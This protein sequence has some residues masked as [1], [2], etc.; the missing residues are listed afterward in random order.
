MNRVAVIS[1]A[2]GLMAGLVAGG[3]GVQL[4][5]DNS[6]DL[7]A[8]QKRAT[9][10]VAVERRTL[11]VTESTTGELASSAEQSLTT[12]GSGTITMAATVGATV[13]R[14]GQLARVDDVPSILLTGDQPVW[15]SFDSSMTDGAD[16]RQ[17]ESNLVA[18]GFDP[19][20][21][22]VDANFDSDTAAAIKAWETSLGIP[23]PDGVVDAGQI[24]FVAT[25]VQVT[26]STTAGTRLNAGDST[27]TVRPVDGAGLK[28]TFTV[29]EEADRYQV[30]KPVAIVLT[31]ESRHAATIS[32]FERVAIAGGQQGGLGGGGAQTASF[33]VT[34]TPDHGGAGLSAGPV[35]VEIPT[36]RASDALAVPS[37]ALVAVTE[38]GQ[39][40]RLAD[41]DRLVAV[42]IGV[43]ADGWV[44]VTGDDIFEGTKIV[45]PK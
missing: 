43:F 11:D 24:I 33:T 22:T 1:G 36:D 6:T 28:L 13:D 39:A 16:V 10:T 2:L 12:I 21:M 44:E 3:V 26:A 35:N 30:G 23:E 38:G 41:G 20:S 19:K 45:V 27:A 14:G 15:R 7:T 9:T 37:R 31:D 32:S 34:A 8:A 5:D 42:T 4:L 18:L 40:L 25:A 29:T 17:L